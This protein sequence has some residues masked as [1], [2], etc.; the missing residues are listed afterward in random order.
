MKTLLFTTTLLAALNAN[1][2]LITF[3]DL[4]PTTDGNPMPAG[5]AGLSWN[6][7]FYIN[8]NLNGIN[9]SGYQAG[10]VSADIVVGNGYGQ[11]ALVGSSA[12]NLV[13][14]YLTAAWKDNLQ[15]T[16]TASLGGVQKYQEVYTLSATAP[17]LLNFNFWDVD[18]VKFATSGGTTHSGY[19]STGNQFVMDNLT[20]AAVPEPSTYLAG[21]SALGMILLGLKNRK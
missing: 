14:A 16:V 2:A 13:S 5:Y 1:A 3:D 6:N 19:D 15:L 12:F 7:F 17:T 8:G 21:F 11:P 10:V 4:V 9:P 18:S 20:V